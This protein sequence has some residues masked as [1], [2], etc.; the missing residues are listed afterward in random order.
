MVYVEYPRPCFILL[1]IPIYLFTLSIMGI[2]CMYFIL[3]Y[4]RLLYPFMC[5]GFQAYN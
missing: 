2:L 4:A 3:D 5:L 1:F